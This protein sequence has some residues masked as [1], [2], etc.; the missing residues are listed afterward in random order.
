MA[1]AVWSEVDGRIQLDDGTDPEAPAMAVAVDLDMVHPWRRWCGPMSTV[2]SSSTAARIQKPPPWPWQN[3][4]PARETPAAWVG[5]GR[6][7]RSPVGSAENSSDG[8]LCREQQRG[9][10][11][12]PRGCGRASST[13]MRQRERHVLDGDRDA[14]RRGTVTLALQPL[15]KRSTTFIE[16]DADDLAERV[17][18]FGYEC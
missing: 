7:R 4:S 11:L 2:T 10:P 14:G 8:A 3:W 1:A 18:E 16:R 17:P 15:F 12:L 5:R 6:R 9:L 13:G